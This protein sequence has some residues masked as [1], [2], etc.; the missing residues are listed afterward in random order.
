VADLLGAQPF[1]IVFTSGGTESNNMAL[2]GAARARRSQG[3]H[4]ITSAIEHPAILEVC[5]YL[6]QEGFRITRV[7]VDHSGL[8]D[9]EDIAAAILPETIL[10][11][12]MHANN[13]VGTIQP[14]SEIGELAR[15]KGI[16]M[17]T[18]AAQSVGK[19]PVRVNDLIVDLLSV[20][21]H[22]LYAP[23][24]IGALYVRQGISLNKIA[25]GADHEM[26]RRPGTEN[27]LEIAGLGKACEQIARKAEEFE[28]HM[29]TMRNQLKDLILEQCPQAVVH[30]HPEKYLPNTLSIGFP[31]IEAATLL[32][33]VPGVAA[34]AGAAC[35]AGQSTVSG[36]LAAMNVSL[37]VAMGTIRLTT[38]RF[39]TSEEIREAAHLISE[40]VKTL[41]PDYQF[42][43][44]SKPADNVRLTQFTHGLG[45]ACKLRP[46]D[47]ERVVKDLKILPDPNILVGTETADDAAVYR[48][49]DTIA[50]V[51]TVD[52][53]TPVV[54]DPRLF[55]AI[56]A[57]NA[58]SDIYAMGAEPLFALNIVGFPVKRLDLGILKEILLG[59]QEKAAEAGISVLGGHT[60]EDTEPKY[61]MVV[62]GRVHPERIWTNSGARPGDALIL[63]KPIGSGIYSTALK[64]GLL[65]DEE[66]SK[67]YRIM[68]TL[69][70]QASEILHR[71][72]VHACTDVTGFGLIGHLLE[73]T[74]GSKVNAVMEIG[75]VPFL[76]EVFRLIG[77]GVVPGGTRNNLEHAGDRVS[78]PASLDPIRKL[79]LCDAQTSG[80]L[81]AALPGPEAN[82]VLDEMHREGI[83]DAAIIGTIS[84][85]GSG[86]IF[87][88]A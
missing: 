86:R 51:E 72:T 58:L 66:A 82:I 65:P 14:I 26:N 13:E 8:I 18:D 79:A 81:L 19:I 24:G 64:Q 22:K 37:D 21:G 87:V 10:I 75:R 38:G 11:S 25:Y 67:A 27:V 42:R 46:Q 12:V 61:G 50:L 74:R 80:G 60:I 71:F 48:I 78:W 76:G 59:A 1:E 31:G 9:P 56:A 32:A 5:R 84:E 53:F 62:T 20:A 29:R 77:S 57:A 45:C 40:A 83:T 7:P 3:N 63:T 16:W 69:N 54:D 88:S 36:V 39:T 73:M 34:S 70:R 15:R 47:L 30:G 43:Q 33:S 55:G 41:T 17:H 52:F 85:N 49:N 2:I 68:S 4:I 6:E 44:I 35:H 28:A 23:K